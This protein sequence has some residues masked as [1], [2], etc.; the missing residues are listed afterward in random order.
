M[1]LLDELTLPAAQQL[2]LDEVLLLEAESEAAEYLRL[3][4][5]EK[6]AVILG[7]GSRWEDEA[8]VADCRDASVSMLRRCSGGAAIV[9]GPGCLFYSVVLNRNMRPELQSIDG[10]HNFV[11]LRLE[12]ALRSHKVA[13]V[14]AGTSDVAIATN[15]GLQKVSGNSLRLRRDYLLYHGTVLYA[16][17]LTWVARLLKTPPR[18]PDYRHGRAHAQFICNVP[19]GGDLLRA[20]LL[21]EWRPWEKRS[22]WPADKCRELAKTKYATADWTERL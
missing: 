2:A 6:P 10:A 15:D 4:E 5:L 22:D 9:G 20:A 13:A 1:F 11:L 19:V 3:W 21:N 17:D 18:Q 8:R 7:R 12:R 16:A 14:L